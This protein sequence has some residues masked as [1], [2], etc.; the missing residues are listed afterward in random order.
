MVNACLR[1]KSSSK[2]TCIYVL[3]IITNNLKTIFHI[4]AWLL[5][6][7][8]FRKNNS[9]KLLKKL[10][11]YKLNFSEYKKYCIIC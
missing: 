9:K 4:Y 11:K 3:K 5:I 1:Y 8:I 6:N 7:W 10:I 2:Q